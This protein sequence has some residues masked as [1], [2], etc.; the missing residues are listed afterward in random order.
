MTPDEE[1][2]LKS[3]YDKL[4]A[5]A[6]QTDRL[7][8][9]NP[10]IGKVIRKWEA[11]QNSGNFGDISLAVAFGQSSVLAQIGK[12]LQ[13]YMERHKISTRKNFIPV[14]NGGDF[15]YKRNSLAWRL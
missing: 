9:N 11:E 7:F 4:K 3:I 2:E 12:D 13:V 6:V 10:A 8:Q 14:K 15:L 1:R 5:L